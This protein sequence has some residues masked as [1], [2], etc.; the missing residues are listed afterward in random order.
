MFSVLEHLDTMSRVARCVGRNKYRLDAIVLNQLFERRIRFRTTADLRQ[1]LT[2][3][4]EQIAYCDDV[5]VWMVLET[6][7]R[8]ELADAVPNDARTDLAVGNRFPAFGKVWIFGG[9]LE[10]LDR[11][12]CR[13]RGLG[14]GHGSS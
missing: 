2:A 10:A 4:R 8:T 12:L 6:K 3:V 13:E 9:F 14:N 5:D 7:L 1:F 11:I